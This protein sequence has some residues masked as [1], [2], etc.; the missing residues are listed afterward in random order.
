MRVAV[1][2][3]A[4]MAFASTAWTQQ[5][6]D[7]I[8]M[9]YQAPKYVAPANAPS[10][11]VIAGRNEPGDRLIVTGRALDQGMP[12]PDVSVYAF[13]ADASGL[14]ANDG[15]NT[16]Q[17]ARLAA[18]LRTDAE[19]R[20]RYETIRPL[21]SDGMAAR[22]RHVVNAPGY[23]PRFCDLWLGDDPYFVKRR[24]AS[25][26]LSDATMLFVRMPTRGADGVWQVTHDLE[27]LRY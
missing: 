22:L 7:V 1:W 3:I 12:V 11:A 19:G 27:L 26:P 8:P 24:E 2:S 20:Y 21:G 17:N 16:D 13:H 6:P 23:K 9:A 4:A 5:D 25:L 14:Y 18:A 15:P 10:D